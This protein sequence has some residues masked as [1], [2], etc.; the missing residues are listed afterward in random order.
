MIRQSPT[1]GG[2]AADDE[3]E[4]GEGMDDG[5]F[6]GELDVIELLELFS[7]ATFA[8]LVL[9]FKFMFIFTVSL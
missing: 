2:I 7:I 6:I 5:L 3:D 9:W 1:L 4:I 8:R